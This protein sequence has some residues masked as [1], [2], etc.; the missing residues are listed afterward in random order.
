MI[1]V[2]VEEELPFLSRVEYRPCQSPWERSLAESLQ[3]GAL[4]CVSSL[5]LNPLLLKRLTQRE[6]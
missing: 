3:I 5:S 2:E 1:K 6:R 4:N